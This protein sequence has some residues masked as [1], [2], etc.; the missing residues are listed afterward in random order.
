MPSDNKRRGNG[1]FIMQLSEINDLFDGV[2]T[3]EEI[4]QIV[5]SL[6]GEV[7]A[8]TDE[9]KATGDNS[10][11]ELQSELKGLRDDLELFIEQIKI[12]AED[13]D[14]TQSELAQ[15][16]S[17]IEAEYAALADKYAEMRHELDEMDTE[18]MVRSIVGETEHKLRTDLAHKTPAQIRDELLTL[19]QDDRFPAQIISNWDNI[20]KEWSRVIS[21]AATAQIEVLQNGEKV[22]SSH[23]LNFSS[24][25]TITFNQGTVD[26]A[27]DGLPDQTGNNG[28]FLRTDGTDATW[29]TIAGGGDLLA[30]NNL[31]DVANTG[32]AR[33]NLGVGTGDSPQFT[34]VNVGHATDTTVTRASAGRIAVEG[35][36]VLM[37]S[38]IGT[39]VQAYD[40]E[41]AA[42][43]GLTSAANKVPMFSG[44]GT[45]TVIDFKDE[46]NMASDSATAVP[47][48]QSTKA[49]VDTAVALLQPKAAITDYSA[50]TGFKDPDGIQIDYDYTN[51]TITLTGDLTYYWK[52]TAKSLSS[53]WTST[54][55]TN[56]T[57]TWF[58][59]STDG[60]NF[61]WSNSVWNFTH[62]MVALV[63]RGASAAATFAVRET[64]GMMDPEAHE[65][66]HAV[67]GTYRSS[68]GGVTAGTYAF[69]TATDAA[70]TMGFD[71]A[72]VKDEDLA[73][74]IPQWTEGTYTTMYIG[75]SNAAT[76]D[77]T[78]SYPFIAAGANNFIQVN[79]TSTGSMTAGIN[80][81]YYN[82]YQ[83]LVPATADTDSQKYR[84]IMIQPQATYTSLAA[85][86]GESINAISL[87][88]FAS[89]EYVIYARITY[90]TANADTNYGKC[91]IPTGGITYVLG[92]R[93][94]Q[95]TVNGVS[96]TAHTSLSNLTWTS[97]G[98]L[99]TASS[100][101]G[102]NSGGTAADYAVDTD[103]SSV[104]ANDDTVPSAK[105]TKA[106]L[107]AK[108]PL[109]SPTF[110]GTVTLPKTTEINDTT[111]DHQ[112]VLAVSELS[113]DR[114]VTLPLLTG[115]DEFV[116]KDHTQTLTNKTLTSPT[117]TTPSAFT[118]G[119][120]I[121]LAENTSIALDPAGS[122]DG[123]Y[124]GITVTGTSGY[125]QAF[126][127]LVYLDPTDSRWEA[128]DA[129]SASGAD[130]DARG[131]LGMVVST[132]TDG[133]ACTILL[134]GI[135]RA[136]AKFPTFTINNPIYASE[137]AGSVTQTQPTT[138]DVVI[139][140]VGSALTA[141][142]M[143]F[144]PDWAWVTHT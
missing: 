84:M 7:K 111:G 109:A 108:A 89:Q 17:R 28:K 92:N 115:A 43:A 141:D 105:A 12:F 61:T 95:T 117:L 29:E 21:L 144:N 38:D 3:K 2:A 76:F 36:N 44:S 55:H 59:Y 119:G 34:A 62:V 98:H 40:A 58:L 103:L 137:T 24:G 91:E 79:D 106:A 86:Q 93:V 138:T 100:V 30:V 136:D 133:N 69:N 132:G 80:G 118:T 122:A 128:V 65:E 18:G 127:D 6:T 27:L 8:I 50:F 22:G 112:Y 121:T 73:T 46:D 75:A 4:A 42:V 110:T 49:Y 129:N 54:A 26:I 10:R 60:D 15:A 13:N 14:L 39:T 96:P 31:S 74:T 120:T 37:A 131:M 134:N 57:G 83:L 9:L 20:E 97:S 124:T 71:A 33:T 51:R 107:D 70:V 56:S 32:T 66:L 140:I 67:I 130:G 19:S 64:H 114:T 78:S 82:V 5:K 25:S 104:S 11:G 139:R 63:K 88:D 123:K 94:A 41:L 77:T 16:R 81:R 125:S 1:Q 53:P 143:Y 90:V 126:G 116:F 48:Q 23:R 101:A 47:S 113:A 102:F 52:G 142:E 99:G 85:A 72:V 87:G 68:G 35:S 45:A 135:I